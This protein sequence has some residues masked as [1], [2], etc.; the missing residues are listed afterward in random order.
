MDIKKKYW[1]TSGC[2][3]TSQTIRLGLSYT[4]RGGQSYMPATTGYDS[5][6]PVWQVLWRKIKRD[7]KKV[8]SSS[9]T[10]EGIYD[11]ETYSKNFDQGTGWLEPDNYFRSFSARFAD[12]SRILSPKHLLDSWPDMQ[13][14]QNKVM[15]TSGFSNVSSVYLWWCNSTNFAPLLN[16]FLVFWWFCFAF[17]DVLDKIRLVKN[18]CKSLVYATNIFWWLIDSSLDPFP[19]QN[20][21]CVI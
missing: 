18:I 13:D 14:I 9:I 17:D 19:Y 12:P 11:P 4:Q 5:T 1:F 21:N 16:D 2:K 8:F 10:M 6:R 7:K 15:Y 3:Q 20:Q